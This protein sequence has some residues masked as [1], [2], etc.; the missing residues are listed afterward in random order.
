[1]ADDIID[2]TPPPP[3]LIPPLEALAIATLNARPSNN[4]PVLVSQPSAWLCLA[5]AA[6]L[7][8]TAISLKAM[9]AGRHLL[10]A[11]DVAALSG[12][13]HTQWWVNG[14]ARPIPGLPNPEA[15]WFGRVLRPGVV[16]HVLTIG[17][18]IDDD[19]DIL[20]HGFNLEKRLVTLADRGLALLA[21][22]GFAGPTLAAINLYGLDEVLLNGGPTIGRYQTPSLRL[23]PVLIP[24]A[25]RQSGNFLRSA[26]DQM[27]LGA[28]LPEGSPSFGEDGVWK[29]YAPHSDY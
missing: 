19:R 3:N 22:L 26:F 20:F 13:D 17:R 21:Q 27:W 25:A 7:G 8:A 6:A 5:P 18:R 1:M 10:L 28:G 24:E 16:E 23:T 14:Q 12:Q 4:P 29:G 9:E 15:K 11:D 2:K